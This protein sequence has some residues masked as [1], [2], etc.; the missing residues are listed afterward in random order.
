[1]VPSSTLI[2][3]A[4]LVL[5]PAATL[6]G[7]APGAAMPAVIASAMLCALAGWDAW[8]GHRRMQTLAASLPSSLRWAQGRAASLSLALEN[9][10]ARPAAIRAG[11]VM[12]EGIA[13]ETEVQPATLPPG[14]ASLLEWHC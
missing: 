4:A 9:R 8:D 13:C 6:A 3:I 14:Q 11:L 10:D 1:M 2:A 7:V 5:I 12:P